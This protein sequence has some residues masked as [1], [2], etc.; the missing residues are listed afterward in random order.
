MQRN[1][2]FSIKGVAVDSVKIKH[3]YYENITRD[4]IMYK[5]IIKK[6]FTNIVKEVKSWEK[7]TFYYLCWFIFLS[8]L[9][10]MYDWLIL[11][12]CF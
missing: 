11:H 8:L 2:I 4:K 1:R 9:K 5:I 12:F 10:S 6:S 7:V 3:Y